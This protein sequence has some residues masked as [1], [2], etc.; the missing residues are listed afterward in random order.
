[1]AEEI[2]ITVLMGIYNC[3]ATL[4]EALESLYA[5]TY[6]GFKVVLCDDGSTDN[7][8][9]VAQR[10][11]T[12][13]PNVV[14]IRNER[15]MG[16][17]FTLNHCLEHADTEYCARMDGD[18]ISLPDR[19][20]KEINFLDEHPEYDIVSG[21]MNYF[22]ES[23]IFRVGHGKGEITKRDFIAG[24]PICHAPCMVRTVAYKAVGGYTVDKRLLRVEDYHLWFKM[25]ASGYKAYMLKD[26]IY[27]MR[28]DRNA[29]RRRKFRGYWN[30]FNLRR[31]GYDMLGLPKRV[32]IYALRPLLV[33]AL[34]NFL[35]NYL[36]RRK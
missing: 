17:N 12:A 22:D 1:M 7:T 15:N 27:S 13:H 4:D 21:P 30:G 32:K 28:D 18:D 5:Q 11:A 29:A 10:H 8:Y 36:H 31:K 33:W 35:Y 25:Y 2:R 19:F 9:E 3:A 6:Q 20:E 34:P 16:L 26:P 14:L 24:T 23:G